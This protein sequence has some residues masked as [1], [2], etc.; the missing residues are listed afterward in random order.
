MLRQMLKL[1]LCLLF[2]TNVF[3]C[4]DPASS[5]KNKNTRL[6]TEFPLEVG[7]AWIY[8]DHF[9]DS[10]ETDV[11][12]DTLYVF[13]KDNQYYL[14]SW[15]PT[16]YYSLIKNHDN[17]STVFLESI[18]FRQSFCIFNTK[19]KRILSLIVVSNFFRLV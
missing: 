1:F 4:S 7:T 17:K 15:D 9:Y 12:Y 13:G 14:Y 16:Y 10:G 11:G 6:P 2:L 18:R 3:N 19:L 5:K 8:E